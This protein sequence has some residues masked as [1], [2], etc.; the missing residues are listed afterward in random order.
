MHL[1]LTACLPP[2]QAPQSLRT[3]PARTGRRQRP[4]QR[5]NCGSR[6]AG[7]RHRPPG[8]RSDRLRPSLDG[9]VHAARAKRP[10]RLLGRGSREPGL[11]ELAQRRASRHWSPAI[12]NRD[13]TDGSRW[14]VISMTSQRAA[15]WSTR[16]LPL[17]A[18][19][20]AAPRTNAPTWSIRACRDSSPISTPGSSTSPR[21]D[22][23]IIARSASRSWTAT[24][25]TIAT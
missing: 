8:R 22:P 25:A 15:S 16:D 14:P 12:L 2:L 9:N 5:C 7:R 6:D 1:I 24:A 18:R 21:Q 13:P 10:S 17:P 23:R 11:S 3:A 20:G 4:D 19:T